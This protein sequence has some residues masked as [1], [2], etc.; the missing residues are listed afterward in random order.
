MKY[1]LISFLLAVVVL[2]VSCN[3]QNTHQIL[4][5][6]AFQEKINTTPDA[7]ILDVRTPG[8]YNGGYI[9][10]AVNINYNDPSFEREIT[11]LD[12]NKTYLLYCLSGKRSG[13]AMDYMLKNGF[14][15]V[16]NLDGG[17]LAWQSVNLPVTTAGASVNA[18]KISMEMYQQMIHSS[19][20]VVLVD[21]FAPWC[22][23]CIKMK[24][25]L[26][27]V[28][29]AYAGKVKVFRVDIDENKVLAKQLNVTE[30]PILKTF[31]KGKETWMHKGFIDKNGLEKQLQQA[32]K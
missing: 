11:K 23:P 22:A 21:F 6:A 32:V 25:M 19:D 20:T 14:K 29:I 27:E 17:I 28:A 13:S 4:K 12:K 30:I 1:K 9:A 5:P 3:S 24:P 8:E 31:V 7:V 18:D 15:N 26:E 16:S 10:N 2:S